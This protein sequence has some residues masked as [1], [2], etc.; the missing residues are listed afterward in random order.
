ME[1]DLKP[2]LR[3]MEERALILYLIV[4]TFGNNARNFQLRTI[5]L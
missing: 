5:I 1:I 4:A 3:L 2:S